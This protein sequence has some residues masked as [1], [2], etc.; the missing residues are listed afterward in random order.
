MPQIAQMN[1]DPKPNRIDL[2][3]L[4]HLR[5]LRSFCIFLVVIA[6]TTAMGAE[7]SVAGP[8]TVPILEI[9]YFPVT[10][11]GTKI[12][13]NVTSNVGAPL[14]TIRKKCDRMTREAMAALEEGS[15]FRAYNNAAAKASIKFEVLATKEYLEPLPRNE[16]KPKFPDYTKILE[17]EDIRRWVEEKGVKEVWIWGYHSKDLAPW[18][19]NMAS[20][21]GDI[22][23]SDRDPKDLPILK[24]T[25]TVY[26]Y[27]YERD[28]S[29][30]VHNHIHQ[31]EAVMRH[32]GR[33][34]WGIFEGKK[35][36]WR[37]GN[38]HFPPNA[39]H[40]YDWANKR[41]VDSDIEDWRPEGFGKMKRIN[42][43]TWDGDG[44]KWFVYWMRSIPGADNGLTYKGRPL[45]HWW[46]YMGDYD[47]AVG[48]KVG[49]VE[50]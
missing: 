17:R 42:C 2:R 5:Y 35:G 26:H 19:S 13:I 32:H 20:Q 50:R 39:E 23:N 22:S 33:E 29:E 45:T 44:L 16:K 21:F 36:A 3:N 38:C 48:K 6:A 7:E 12:D 30:A 40:D 25:Y 10:A 14:E 15:R 47:L 1:A 24:R 49:L 34:L 9:R 18:E 8:W 37:A 11:D 31:I 4:R 46:V 41:F 28:T 43:D 27:N